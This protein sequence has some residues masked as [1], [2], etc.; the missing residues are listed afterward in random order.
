MPFRVPHRASMVDHPRQPQASKPCPVCGVFGAPIRGIPAPSKRCSGCRIVY[1][2]T[3]QDGF[4]EELYDY[5]GDWMSW[6]RERVY[7]AINRKGLLQVLGKLGSRV[8]G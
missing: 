5:Y 1:R 4:V 8:A 6:P 2:E 7:P 3:W